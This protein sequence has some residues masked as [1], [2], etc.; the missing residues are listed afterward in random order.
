MSAVHGGRG[1]RR[2]AVGPLNAPRS[3]AKRY[4]NSL[5]QLAISVPEFISMFMFLGLG[6]KFSRYLRMQM[7]RRQGRCGAAV[8]EV[9]SNPEV[10]R[11][12]R[13]PSAICTT[14]DHGIE[15]YVSQKEFQVT[16]SLGDADPIRTS[17]VW[18]SKIRFVW[19]GF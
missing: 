17:P 9:L 2:C 18:H 14:F 19:C 5:G 16:F 11:A 15:G 1:D 6:G 13:S 7:A 10:W 12:V 8:C 4:T 3:L